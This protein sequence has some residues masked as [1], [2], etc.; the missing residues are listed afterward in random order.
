M[1]IKI[2]TISSSYEKFYKDAIAEYTKRLSRYC[3][4]SLLEFKTKDQLLQK[5]SINDYKIQVFSDGINISSEDLSE[6]IKLLGLTGNSSVTMIIGID[7]SLDVDE[8]L[9]LSQMKMSIPLEV[10]VLLEQIY[11]AYRILN[12][13]AYHK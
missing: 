7:D 2:M 13:Q 6:K 10:T 9:S 12:N 4:L 11:R 5:V 3:K 8:S 1:N